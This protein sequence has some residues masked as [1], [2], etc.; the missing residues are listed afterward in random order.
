MRAREPSAAA[1]EVRWSATPAY[2]GP[3]EREYF[4][5]AAR[6]PAAPV[7]WRGRAGDDGRFGAEGLPAGR[8]DVSAVAAD[9]ARSERALFA[10]VDGVRTVVTLTLLAA[11]ETLRGRVLEDDGRPAICRLLAAGRPV[12]VRSDGTFEIVGLCAGPCGLDAEGPDCAR[13][14]AVVHLP[15]TTPVT[16]RLRRPGGERAVRVLASP[17]A[18]PIEG[19]Q[20]F[21]LG[22][23]G[24]VVRTDRDGRAR[25]P[26]RGSA[27][28]KVAAEGYATVALSAGQ[29]E[30]TEELTVHLHKSARIEGR[31][32]SA[33]DG[34][35]LEGVLVEASVGD[36]RASEPATSAVS[37]AD[38]TYVLEDLAPGA[39]TV[40]ARGKTSIVR[41]LASMPADDAF[42]SIRRERLECDPLLVDVLP[43]TTTLNL[44]M[45]PGAVLSGR[46]LDAAG[47]PAAGAAVVVYAPRAPY[48]SSVPDPV[49]WERYATATDTDGRYEFAALLPGRLY[50]VQASAPGSEARVDVRVPADGGPAVL[51]V[52]LPA[53]FSFDVRV[54][55]E[56]SGL[57]LP[58]ALVGASNKYGGEMTPEV[59]TGEDGWA[60]LGPLPGSIEKV[61]AHRHRE[62]AKVEQAIDL[63]GGA[64]TAPVVLRLP[65]SPPEGEAGTQ[66]A[67]AGWLL[68]W[69]EFFRHVVPGG[70]GVR[71]PRTS[72]P[73]FGGVPFTVTV[74]DADGAPV[75][76]A[77]LVWWDSGGRR[78]TEASVVDGST[79]LDVPE[80]IANRL[81]VAVRH[82][83]DREDLALPVGP[84]RAGPLDV[85]TG[86]AELRLPAE[87]TISGRVV[88]PDG[89][90]VRGVRLHAVAVDWAT[91]AARTFVDD[92]P[93][94]HTDGTGAFRLRG[95]AAGPHYVLFDV[96]PDFA[97]VTPSVHESGESG[98]EFRLRPGEVVS[99]RMIDPEGRPV[100]GASVFVSG[101]AYRA[102]P[103]PQDLWLGPR[104]GGESGADGIVRLGGMSREVPCGFEATPPTGR[105]DLEPLRLDA[106]VPAS[107]DLAFPGLGIVRGVVRGAD[108]EPIPR[109]HIEVLRGSTWEGLG[110]TGSDGVFEVRVPT[111]GTTQLSG[112][113][114]EVEKGDPDGIYWGER[115]TYRSE[116]VG[117]EAG[118][119]GVVLVVDRGVDLAVRVT[120]PGTRVGWG[121]GVTYD[122]SLI[123][124]A[125]AASDHPGRGRAGS[126]GGEGELYRFHQLRADRTYA[127]WLAPDLAGF[128]VLAKGLR[129]VKDG[130]DVTVEAVKG[131]PVTGRIVGL[132]DVGRTTISAMQGFIYVYGE[133]EP[134]GRFTFPGLPEGEWRMHAQVQRDGRM[135]VAHAVV[136]AGGDAD[137]RLELQPEK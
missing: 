108:G 70:G 50:H 124:E 22:C 96:P 33:A 87:R 134:D 1:I 35:A 89:G 107:G 92:Y 90:G 84:A 63:A 55:D 23:R 112:V 9:G 44:E 78:G 132:S 21:T 76:S 104:Q 74:L 5:R 57:G 10:A 38:G 103:F 137:L 43:G 79:R 51:D 116:S 37:A 85:R 30:T 80:S 7:V 13:V 97:P 60:R 91:L 42:S 6:D 105:A 99:L 81:W 121:R 106:W 14:D 98:V 31:V 28:L 41:G 118:A 73:V 122:G 77:E 119:S 94:A 3:D 25:A 47:L 117:V 65:A 54:I 82:P 127:F 67:S 110:R 102:Q 18:I 71:E 93:E 69:A 45:V 64:P 88:G 46:V 101:V 136:V 75:P 125:S 100:V 52:R 26:L 17:G 20:V 48:I 126:V 53:S 128:Y 68:A 39:W 62:A 95:L 4:V 40:V 34:R 86:R 11:R 111:T 29:R 115:T 12:E 133:S 129:P 113:V 109:A 8:W 36:F 56:A 19:A 32:R 16:L 123:D 15:R 2:F 66:A 49:Y 58:G 24:P 130:T 120:Y 135:W 59:V 61:S 131:R 83:T 72:E 27:L 114:I